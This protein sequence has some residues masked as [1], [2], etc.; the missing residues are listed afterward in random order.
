MFNRYRTQAFFLKE[1]ERGENDKI[2]TAYTEDFGLITLFAK[3]VRKK[4]AK[5]RFGTSFFSLKEIEFIEG[6][7]YRT[8]TDIQIVE[9]YDSARK[10]LEKNALIVRALQEIDSLIK[11]EEKDEKIWKLLKS[12]FREINQAEK[13]FLSFYFHFI[14]K[15]FSFL[16]YSPKLDFCSQD[17]SSTEGGLIKQ[18]FSNQG[19]KV[20][21]KIIDMLRVFSEESF[22]FKEIEINDQEKKELK[23]LTEKYFSVCTFHEKKIE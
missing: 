11:Q 10:N 16:G 2:F 9:K 13:C 12:F 21:K 15:S 3:G 7:Q 20:S 4:E 14:W 23:E 6:R 19:I 5:L 1:K 17:F 18:D 22:N 8:L